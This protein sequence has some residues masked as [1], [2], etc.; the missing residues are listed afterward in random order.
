MKNKYPYAILEST[1]LKFYTFI[2]VTLAISLVFRIISM[3]T[4]FAGF[5]SDFEHWYT[6]LFSAACLILTFYA[7]LGLSSMK[8][9]GPLCYLSIFAIAWLAIREKKPK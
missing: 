1:P 8:W 4:V 6:L 5:V 2:K 9:Y 3:L 7:L